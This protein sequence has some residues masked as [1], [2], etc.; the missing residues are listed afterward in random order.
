[1]TEKKLKDFYTQYELEVFED[2]R[3]SDDGNVFDEH[4]NLMRM[5]E[6]FPLSDYDFDIHFGYFTRWGSFLSWNIQERMKYL[7]AFVIIAFSALF[8]YEKECGMQEILFSTKNGRRKCT[9]AK[10]GAAFLLTNGVCLLLFLIY[11]IELLCITKGIGWDTSIQMITWLRS[12]TYD[13]N[14]L[15][16]LL[17]TFFLS[18]LAM[19]VALF[20]TLTASFLAKNPVTAMCVSLVVLFLLHPDTLAL[21]VHLDNMT[22]NRI[23][24]LLPMSVLDV[25]NLLKQ[26][27]LKMGGHKLQF[28]TI[29][30]VLYSVV[31]IIGGILFFRVLTRHQKY[32]AA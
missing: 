30:E 6:I 8:T 21:D 3:I 15:G 32:Y 27:P 31:L 28:L 1:M 19:N 14:N 17:H 12:A 18:L 7:Y 13:M 5:D 9:A 2:G 11:T 25:Q 20:I 26:A 4:G 10:V 22:V 24:S 23:T 29:A 16:M